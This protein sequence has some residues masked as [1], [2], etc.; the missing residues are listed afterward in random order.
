MMSDSI[1]KLAPAPPMAAII[2]CKE[3][4]AADFAAAL[5]AAAETAAQPRRRGRPRR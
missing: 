2:Y 5:L 4:A 1:V 3:T